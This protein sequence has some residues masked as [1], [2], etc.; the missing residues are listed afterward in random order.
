MNAVKEYVRLLFLLRLF[1]RVFAFVYPLFITVMYDFWIFEKF[2][3]WALVVYIVVMGMVELIIAISMRR[4]WMVALSQVYL[5]LAIVFEFPSAV[6]ELLVRGQ[7]S[8]YL[9]FFGWAFVWYFPV[10]LIAL[11]LAKE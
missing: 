6:V 5:A 2:P 11:S 1:L 9:P 4:S 8:G 3:S 10:L 7:T